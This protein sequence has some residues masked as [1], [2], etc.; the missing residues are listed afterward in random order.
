MVKGNTKKKNLKKKS[1]S[2]KKRTTS[3]KENGNF[4]NSPYKPPTAPTIAPTTTRNQFIRESIKGGD[5]E[6]LDRYFDILDSITHKAKYKNIYNKDMKYYN[7]EMEKMIGGYDQYSMPNVSRRYSQ[8]DTLRRPSQYNQYNPYNTQSELSQREQLG[9]YNPSSEFGQQNQYNPSFGQMRESPSFGQIR[10]TPS[11]D[12]LPSQR[13]QYNQSSQ[14]NQHNQYRRTSKKNNKPTLVPKKSM[15]NKLKNKAKKIIGI[16][17]LSNKAKQ[18]KKEDALSSYRSVQTKL[19]RIDG[20]LEQISEMS[21]NVAQEMAPGASKNRIEKLS[22]VSNTL[23]EK[24][25][26]TTIQEYKNK[27]KKMRGTM[28][29]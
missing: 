28:E 10:E 12:Q 9:Q 1:K 23:G 7:K 13:N 5:Y 6:K 27:E 11:F 20:S 19:Q 15:F 8:P 14:H 24:I 25:L 3:K 29:E 17:G 18:K 16:E 22:K 21:A 4:K 2:S 26:N